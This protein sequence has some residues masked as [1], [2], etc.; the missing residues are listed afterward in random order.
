[1][2]IST[3]QV[4]LLA[5]I[6]FT[7]CTGKKQNTPSEDARNVSTEISNQHVTAFAEDSHGQIWIGTARG[8]NKYVGNTYYQ[9]FY[10]DN[11]STC[12]PDNQVR[13]MLSDTKG[14][15]WIGTANGI[16]YYTKKDDFHHVK[17]DGPSPNVLQICEDKDGNI[18]TNMYTHVC[19]YDAESDRFVLAIPNFNLYSDSF[20]G[21][22]IDDRGNLWGTGSKHIAGYRKGSYTLIYNK[23]TD[24]VISSGAIGKDGKQWLII[25]GKLTIFDTHTMNFVPLPTVISEGTMLSP[26]DVQGLTTMGQASILMYTAHGLYEYNY[27]RGT[28]VKAFDTDFISKLNVAL[29]SLFVDSHKNLWLGTTDQSFFVKYRFKNKFNYNMSMIFHL[30]HKSVT[31]LCA[32]NSGGVWIA[33]ARDG[34]YRYS[35]STGNVEDV[36]APFISKSD[37]IMR[38]FIDSKGHIWLMTS[39]GKI[40]C[41][42]A[43]GGNLILSKSYSM[44]T[45]PFAMTEMTN[46][47]IFMTGYDQCIYKLSNG[48]NEFRSTPLVKNRFCF[49]TSIANEGDKLLLASFDQDIRI[50]DPTTLKTVGMIPFRKY[51]RHTKII[52][53]CIYKDSRGDIWIGTISNGL[54]KMHHR[55]ITPIEGL[56]CS[57]VASIEEDNDGNMWISTYNGL[58]KYDHHTGRVTQYYKE[59]GI[60]G[61]QFNDRSS[62]ITPDGTL[63]FGGTHG[64]TFFN[65]KQFDIRHKIK[66]MFE[67]L[68]VYDQFIIPQKGGCIE[69]SLNNDPTI[70]LNHNQRSFSISFA[71]I[72]Y[73]EFSNVQYYYRIKDYDKYWIKAGSNH[74]AFYSNLPPGHYTF[75]VKITNNDENN[76]IAV[77]SIQ[78]QVSPAPWLSIWAIIIY[79]IIAS[80]IVWNI[81]RTRRRIQEQK[82]IAE[83]E[84][85]E[86]EMEWH[87]NQMNM[88]FFSNVSHEFRTPLTMISGPISTL[89]KDKRMAGEQKQLLGIVQRSVKRMLK[90][91]NQLLD[92]QKLENDVVKVE[93]SYSDIISKIKEFAEIFKINAEEKGITLATEGL[94][95]EYNTW[96]DADKVETIVSNFLSN[97]LKYTPIGGKI[98]LSFDADDKHLRIAV[99]DSG[100]GIPE[101]KMNDIFR[102]YYQLENSKAVQNW[103]TGIGLYYAKRLAEIH[104]GDIEVKNGDEGGAIFT[105]VLPIA[106]D[107]YA[108][109]EKKAEIGNK[110]VNKPLPA[111]K[112]AS[113]DNESEKNDNPITILIVDDDTEI[114]NYLKVYLSGYY[115]VEVRFNAKSAYI[116]LDEI[117]PDI[118]VSDVLMPD[119]DG[120]QFCRMIKQ[121]VAYSHIP[122]I[123]LTAKTLVDDQVR[124][125]HDGANAYVTKPFDPEYLLA[126]IQSQLQNQKNLRDALEHA[127]QTDNIDSSIISSSDTSFMRELYALMENKMSDNELNVT[128]I[129]EEMH[130]SRTKFYYK[131]N[132]LT[133]MTPNEFFKTYKLNRAAELI[134]EGKY[135][136]S[137]IADITGF[138]TL[139][140]FSV[141]FK[142]HFGI[143]PSDYLKVKG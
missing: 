60:G 143:S 123:L 88:R 111:A 118:I 71:A 44:P 9:Y 65:P 108:E 73:G 6:L 94:E 40:F 87:I 25:D 100:P 24:G 19:I 53:N 97:A 39:G 23:K 92:F 110:S 120:F 58:C 99:A 64:P 67:G 127:T 116:S 14:R 50:I 125:L 37:F 137:E 133:G 82:A 35:K 79:I 10:N 103:G 89:A 131:M 106:E 117:K 98:T 107:A 42:T 43:S 91:V 114:A 32:D 134:L 141:S 105:L 59:D 2:K 83:K 124:G 140:H 95:G 96:F 115:K 109:Y 33:T 5:A 102:R 45:F 93:V 132:G 101:D 56:S 52:P 51:A 31:A 68:K 41:C 84:K 63:V 29:T 61:N 62:T 66:V 13:C 113:A 119:V 136:I 81:L 30:F 72:D 126:L 46:G 26:D 7:S 34:L 139:S 75:E 85:H 20:T 57:D 112:N 69:E 90:L 18:Y 36:S 28:L 16:C 22:S 130:I 76:I 129:T 49:T 122:V 27:Q 138:S 54:F 86:K 77:N 135:N 128:R 142:K 48:D 1:M 104:H 3:N 12:L 8:L 121:N 74:E 15:L 38:Y 80:F 55:T 11:D 47:D 17:I 4:L 78:I 70:R 21:L